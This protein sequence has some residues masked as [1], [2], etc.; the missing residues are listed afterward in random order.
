MTRPPARALLGS[1]LFLCLALLAAGGCRRRISQPPL[2]FMDEAQEVAA[3]LAR[4]TE[5]LALMPAIA[6]YKWKHGLPVLDAAREQS[7][8]ARI[9]AQASAHGLDGASAQA[10]FRVQM[11]LAREVQEAE[12]ERLRKHGRPELPPVR[13]LEKDLRPKVE[14]STRRLIEELA[15]SQPTLERAPLR[16]RYAAAAAQALAP[17]GLTAEHAAELLDALAGLRTRNLPPAERLLA[18]KTLR[19]GTTGDYA[20]FSFEQRGVLRG[21]DITLAQR[22]ARAHHLQLRFI[23]TSWASL[24]WD[25]EQGMFDLAASGISVTPE[26]RTVAYFSVPYHRGG[27]TAIGRCR[28]RPQLDSMAAIDRANVRVVVNPG[29][30]NEAFARSQLQNAALRVFPYNRLI[31]EEIVGDRADVMITD[32]VEVAVQTLRHRELCRLT[33]E[34]FGASDKAWLLPIDTALKQ[35]VDQWLAPR[36]QSGEVARTLA[37]TIEATPRQ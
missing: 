9:S 13:D 21:T 6:A 36:V 24:L 16:E 32:D 22:F 23:R 17:F 8:L 3:V 29:G 34:L 31:F 35:L 4:S 5:R 1:A 2:R 19:V 28:D 7:L 15:A 33:N 37:R 30:T 11:R 14:R 26:R 10:L 18:R 20:P 25:H 12:V 27:K